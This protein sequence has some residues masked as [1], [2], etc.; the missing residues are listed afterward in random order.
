MLIEYF[1]QENKMYES[2]QWNISLIY[3]GQSSFYFTFKKDK[4]KM[5]RDCFIRKDEAIVCPVV[6]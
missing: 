4:E 1:L 5:I 3:R 2:V 6:T